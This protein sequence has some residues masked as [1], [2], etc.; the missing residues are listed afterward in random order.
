[1]SKRKYQI[2]FDGLFSSGY[3]GKLYKFEEAEK[4]IPVLAEL[5]QDIYA[6]Y[7][8]EEAVTLKQKQ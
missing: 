3:L 5:N 8:I 7:W 6:S 4:K 1:M 2:H